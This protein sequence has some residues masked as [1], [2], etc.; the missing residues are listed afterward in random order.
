MFVILWLST[1]F[2]SLP[3]PSY[4]CYRTRTAHLLVPLACLHGDISPIQGGEEKNKDCF[5][6]LLVFPI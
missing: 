3:P 5:P 4:H 2:P 6:K 1:D